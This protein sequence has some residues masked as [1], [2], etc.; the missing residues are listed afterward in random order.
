MK[1]GIV[2]V[3]GVQGRNN[4]VYGPDEKVSEGNFPEGNFDKLVDEGKIRQTFPIQNKKKEDSDK[5]EDSKK[6]SDKE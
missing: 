2:I 5:K 1:K 4:K 6:N 3:M